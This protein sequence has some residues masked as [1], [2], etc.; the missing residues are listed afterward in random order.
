MSFRPKLKKNTTRT[1]W[2]VHRGAS[3]IIIKMYNDY[4]SFV[5]FYVEC[6]L[7]IGQDFLDI[8]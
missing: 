5:R 3:L 7:K 6:T 4:G 1:D 2:Q 8:Q